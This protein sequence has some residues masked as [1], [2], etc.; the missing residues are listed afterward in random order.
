M[1][2]TICSFFKKGFSIYL[3]IFGFAGSLLLPVDFLQLQQAAAALYLWRLGFS[4]RW[5]L[6]L[7]STG[8]RL[9]GFSSCGSRT[10]EGWL[11][12]CG[13]PA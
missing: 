3:F 8:S 1:R 2:H 10:L 12:S 4:W 5:L 9:V 11:N 13:A 7:Q 6:L